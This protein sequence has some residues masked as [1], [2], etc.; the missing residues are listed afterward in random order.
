MFPF[1]QKKRNIL[2][3]MTY[4]PAFM[5][6]TI[7]PLGKKRFHLLAAKGLTEWKKKVIY[8][9]HLDLGEQLLHQRLHRLTFHLPRLEKLCGKQPL[10]KNEVFDYFYYY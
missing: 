3:T 7:L 10:N 5:R 4:S 8:F 6:Q 2:L 9:P 1:L